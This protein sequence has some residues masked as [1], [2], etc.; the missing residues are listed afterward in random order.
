MAPVT[1]PE[2]KQPAMSES[3]P[4]QPPSTSPHL[5]FG[6]RGEDI[7]YRS[8]SGDAEISFTYMRGPRIYTD[9][10]RGWKDGRPFTAAERRE[11]LGHAIAFVR[12]H[13]ETPTVVVNTD[14]PL[15]GEWFAI[16][17]ELRGEI[18]G[19]ERITD[20]SY[21][22]TQK[23]MMMDMLEA[24]KGVIVNGMKLRTEEDVDRVIDSLLPRRD[25]PKPQ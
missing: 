9:S 16:C 6:F 5:E 1:I 24:G 12:T 18:A 4:W 3:P 20:Q 19:V 8:A 13:R 23:K 2:A 11:V 7:S 10:M 25:P 17:E 21:R 15:A 22:D 14:D